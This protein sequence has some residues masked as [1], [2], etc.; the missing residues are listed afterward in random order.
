MVDRIHKRDID[1]LDGATQELI[2]PRLTS[3]HRRKI[4]NADTSASHL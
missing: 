3:N 1:L 2:I 4:G